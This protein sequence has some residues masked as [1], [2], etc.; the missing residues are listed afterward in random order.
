LLNQ[1]KGAYS[2]FMSSAT[3]KL[4]DNTRKD[5]AYLPIAGS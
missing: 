2:E 1:S 5:S 3:L 4:F